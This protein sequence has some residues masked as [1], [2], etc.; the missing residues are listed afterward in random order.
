[1]DATTTLLAVLRGSHLLA[2]LLLLGT[3]LTLLAIALPAGP[4]GGAPLVAARQ[5][6]RGCARDRPWRRC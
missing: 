1:M 2:L 6:V 4:A 5:R 3:L